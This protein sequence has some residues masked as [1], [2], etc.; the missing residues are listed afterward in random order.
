[1]LSFL[2]RCGVFEEAA[3]IASEVCSIAPR[4]RLNLAVVDGASHNVEPGEELLDSARK[5]DCVLGWR[6]D[7]SFYTVG[8]PV[9]RELDRC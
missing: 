8:K 3:V 1:V 2:Q 4:I 5:S 6:S 7:S 9:V